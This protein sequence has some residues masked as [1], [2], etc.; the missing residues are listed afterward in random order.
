MFDRIRTLSI[1]TDEWM[2]DLGGVAGQL[3]Y[4]TFLALL[5]GWLVGIVIGVFTRLFLPRGFR[6]VKAA[7]TPSPC[8]CAPS[9]M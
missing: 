5:L 6:T 2:Q 4:S 1:F 8:G 9:R 7:P 3:V